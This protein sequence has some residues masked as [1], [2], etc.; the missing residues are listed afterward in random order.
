MPRADAYAFLDESYESDHYY[1][2]GIMVTRQQ[3][4]GLDAALDDLNESLHQKHGEL[5][6]H[7]ELH[8]H[9]IMQAQDEWIFLRDQRRIGERLRISAGML[10]L[11]TRIG[12]KAFIE[13][14][15]VAGLNRRYRYPDPPHLVTLRH[16]LESINRRAVCRGLQRVKIYADH[17]D[18]YPGYLEEIELYRKIGTPGYRSST[19]SRIDQRLWSRTPGQTR[20]CKLLTLLPISAD[21]TW[22]PTR[23]K[24]AEP[25]PLH[26]RCLPSSRI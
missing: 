17:L 23:V 5:P 24:T 20:R 18:E 25:E 4:E 8:A 2:A 21:D 7:I 13:G 6:Q 12:A 16:I 11:A 15:D 1:V 19:L 3:M 26:G 10:N 14:V 9:R 22:K